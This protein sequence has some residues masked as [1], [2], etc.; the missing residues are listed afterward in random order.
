[1]H[2]SFIHSSLSLVSVG[3]TDIGWNSL[4]QTGFSFFGIRWTLLILRQFGKT[5]S[6]RHLLIKCTRCS[7]TLGQLIVHFSIMHERPRQSGLGWFFFL[8]IFHAASNSL[9]G[10][11]LNFRFGLSLGTFDTF[12]CRFRGPFAFA[13]ELKYSFRASGVKTSVFVGALF[14]NPLKV[15]YGPEF[16]HLTVLL[17]VFWSS[18]F[19]L[20]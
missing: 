5:P 12:C 9:N 7:Y 16:F 11:D 8:I 15:G 19:Q 4:S 10:H 18:L 14:C 1:M 3:W 6:I 17:C 13:M 20:M 2:L